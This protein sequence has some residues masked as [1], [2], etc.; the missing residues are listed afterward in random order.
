MP[1]SRQAPKALH[2]SRGRA[3]VDGAHFRQ[4]ASSAGSTS[5]TTSTGGDQDPCG[6]DAVEGRAIAWVPTAATTARRE[7][8][9]ALQ[10][11]V[12]DPLT[13]AGKPNR[14]A[15]TRAA[16]V[17][18][19]ARVRNRAETCSE[20]PFGERLAQHP[21]TSPCEAISAHLSPRRARV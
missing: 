7:H 9:P 3:P 6:A 19:Q 1:A 18:A 5:P 11:G 20:W 2:V 8:P 10:G 16:Q 13:P 12:L 17:R 14:E 15:R 21:R 4:R